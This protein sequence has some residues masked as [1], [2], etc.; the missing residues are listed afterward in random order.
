MKEYRFS[1]PWPKVYMK[2]S[3]LSFAIAF[4]SL[5][6]IFYLSGGALFDVDKFLDRYLYLGILFVLAVFC[7]FIYLGESFFCRN[8]ELGVDED[9]LWYLSIGKESGLLRWDDVFN[10]SKMSGFCDFLLVNKSSERKVYIAKELLEYKLLREKALNKLASNY[11]NNDIWRRGS[12]PAYW[13]LWF[14]ELIAFSFCSWIIYVIVFLFFDRVLG[15]YCPEIDISILFFLV[16]LYKFAF[17]ET[18]VVRKE[19][20]LIVYYPFFKRTLAL[21][22]GFSIDVD[23]PTK[24]KLVFLKV[25][26]IGHNKKIR[27]HKFKRYEA[28][29]Y[30]FYAFLKN[31][32]E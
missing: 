14:L 7:G 8:K 23:M 22:P 3:M 17:E 13:I 32:Q 2:R 28:D 1:R 26:V 18:K 27:K 4:V 21:A 12:S 29:Y 25:D 19:S 24:G 16:A 31:A 10:I 6:F 5:I 9:G 20:A 11:R 30:L 15:W